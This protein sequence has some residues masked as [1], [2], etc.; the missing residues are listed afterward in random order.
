[1][2]DY[3]INITVDTYFNTLMDRGI[4]EKLVEDMFQRDGILHIKLKDGKTIKEPI[5]NFYN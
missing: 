1:M 3:Q 5:K 2:T 4:E